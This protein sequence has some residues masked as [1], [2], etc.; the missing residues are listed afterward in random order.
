MTTPDVT[1]LVNSSD[2]FDDC[3][4]AFFRL[5]QR[6]WPD[7]AYPVLLNTE[8]KDWSLPGFD[9]R[10]SR[11]AEGETRRLTWSECLIAATDRIETPLLLYFQEDYFIDKAV[12]SDVI[13]RAVEL[14]LANPDIGHIGLTHHG[15]MGPFT[16]SPFPDFSVVGQ[17]ARYRISTQAGLWRPD[18]LRSYL[19]PQENGWMF[20]ILGTRRAHRRRDRFLVADFDEAAGGPAIDYTHTGIIKGQ[21]HKA[22]PQLFAAHGLEMDF[23]RRGFYTPPPYW[24]RKWAVFRK[25]AESPIHSLRHFF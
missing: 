8:T 14:M 10:A 19:D 4:P 3:W 17:H 22:M 20:E 18:V 21:W 13:A 9:L 25:L 12:R 6:H 2:G 11:V 23:E 7:C 16:P 15:S 24:R 1:L 5:L